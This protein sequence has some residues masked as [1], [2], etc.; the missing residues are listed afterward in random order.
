MK[1]PQKK[2][3]MLWCAGS[4]LLLL[5]TL[6]TCGKPHPIDGVKEVAETTSSGEKQQTDIEDENLIDPKQ[7]EDPADPMKPVVNK[8]EM[9]AFWLA[10][11]QLA[12]KLFG[13]EALAVDADG[14]ALPLFDEIYR[15]L[16][17]QEEIAC[18]AEQQAF[19]TCLEALNEP[20]DRANLW[21]CLKLE[22]DVIEPKTAACDEAFELARALFDVSEQPLADEDDALQKQ[23]ENEEAAKNTFGRWLRNL[24]ARASDYVTG[25]KRVGL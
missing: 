8:Q 4:A 24:G 14:Q 12:V 21:P 9:D 6:A 2:N 25:N 17:W 20:A 7:E 23:D 15:K 11:G 3:S 19:K 16:Y 13:L 10:K 22:A 5:A 1:T 18:G